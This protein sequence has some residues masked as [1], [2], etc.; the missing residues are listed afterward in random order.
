METTKHLENP[1]VNLTESK[2]PKIVLYCNRVKNFLKNLCDE[3]RVSIA[4]S[5]CRMDDTL[6]QHVKKRLSSA[7]SYDFPGAQPVSM[8]R[9][10]LLGQMAKNKYLCCEKTDGVRYLC[11]ITKNKSLLIDRN[12][13][14]FGIILPNLNFSGKTQ[15]YIHVFDGELIQDKGGDLPIYLIFDALMVNCKNIMILTFENRL[16]IVNSKV[17]KRLRLKEYF[18]LKE[19]PADD[20]KTSEDEE[21]NVKSQKKLPSTTVLVNLKDFYLDV[22]T[23]VLWEKII[24]KLDH[25]NDGIIYTMNECPYYPGTCQQIIKWKP[26]LLNSV[27]F[28]LKLITSFSDQEYIWGLYARTYESPEYLY[29]CIFFENAEENE[30][31]RKLH[32][33]TYTHANPNPVIV[34]CAFRPDLSYDN[35]I[36]FNKYKRTGMLSAYPREDHIKRD[37]KFDT[38]ISY[39]EKKQ[40]KGGWVIERQ[41]TDKEFP[42]SLMV[43]KNIK[44]TI[45]DPVSIEDIIS[46]KQMRAKYASAG[47]KRQSEAIS[48]KEDS[49]EK[50]QKTD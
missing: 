24:P 2:D 25:A 32:S 45:L 6:K 13:N 28:N 23:K 5:Q 48:K 11:V 14:I 29:D 46:C 15:D 44:E 10:H 3:A 22:H 37:F 34:E 12:Y 16:K 50:R 42:N 27:D 36:R 18:E 38:E 47:V 7:T 33:Q 9:G 1:G 21:G 39:T 26:A 49:N 19:E 40:L 20:Y 4:N 8:E 43:A 41:R 35:L 30:K 17:I 31:W